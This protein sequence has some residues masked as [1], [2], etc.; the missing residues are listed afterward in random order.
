GRKMSLLD[1]IQEGNLGLVRAV[2][3]FDFTKGNKFSTYATWWIRQAIERGIADFANTIRIPVHIVEQFQEY[4]N[5]S[6]DSENLEACK[7]DHSKV[8]QALRM[9]PDSLEGYL[10]L[11]WDK[12]Y[13]ESQRSFDDRI[14]TPEV[15]T[16]D[17]EARVLDAEF[18]TRVNSVVDSLPAREA[19]IIRRR[20][21][22]HGDGPQTLDAIGK[23]FNLTRERI[24]QLEKTSLQTLRERLVNLGIVDDEPKGV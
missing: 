5:C 24:R 23:V 8:A 3:K 1:L 20:F 16:E 6:K 9:Q 22:W 2:Q 12:H 17:P 11:Q 10:A 7:H 4:W 14:A 21:G 13:A 15:F 19:E 18:L